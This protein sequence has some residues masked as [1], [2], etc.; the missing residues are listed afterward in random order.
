M[1]VRN[2][3]GE[4]HPRYRLGLAFCSRGYRVPVHRERATLSLMYRGAPS[5]SL[6]AAALLIVAACA[7]SAGGPEPL[8]PQK[9]VVATYDG[10]E[11]E[12]FGPKRPEPALMELSWAKELPPLHVEC[13][14]TGAKADIRLYAPDGAVDPVALDVFS[15]VAAD[16]NGPFP[17]KERLVQLAIKAAHHFDVKSL[18]VVSGYRKPRTKGP[19]DHHTKGEA[20]DFRLPGVDYRQLAAY[21][22]SLSRVGVGV[23]T[24][25]RTHYVHLDVRDR[26]F[27][28]LD[29]SPPGV[30]WREAP[31]RDAKLA[32]RDAA[33]SAEGD[34]PLDRR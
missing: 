28:W 30:V 14:N 25:P 9:V 7:R 11:P 19:G 16:A 2:D 22:R 10:E 27:Y 20:L 3:A 18:V 13:A 4:S 1:W 26:S 21:L 29:A 12:P 34:L 6:A 31:I 24:D 23:Y 32:S 33:Y 8:A 15:H 5:R 17:L